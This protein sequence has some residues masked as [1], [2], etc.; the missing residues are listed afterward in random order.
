MAWVQN[1]RAASQCSAV[2]VLNE[3]LRSRKDVHWFEIALQQVGTK[4][5][6]GA[7]G[8]DKDVGIEVSNGLEHLI[9]FCVLSFERNTAIGLL[10]VFM[11]E[12]MPR[13]PRE[14]AGQDID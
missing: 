4:E 9:E 2:K 11:A 10:I 6:R 1:L 12:R 14:L 13:G 8:G 5:N 7:G 3:L